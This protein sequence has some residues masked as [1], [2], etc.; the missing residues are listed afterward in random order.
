MTAT[1]DNIAL[2]RHA[3]ALLEQGDVDGVRSLVGPGYRIHETFCDELTKSALPDCH[4]ELEDVI[5]TDDKVV[6]RYTIHGTHSGPGTLP[7][8]GYVRPTGRRVELE[9]IVIHR[10]ANGKIAEGWG[11]VDSLETMLELGLVR[12][13]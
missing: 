4:I 2:V 3:F 6:T 13:S 8:F 7:G 5:A 12:P 11:C 10:I 9:G 1:E